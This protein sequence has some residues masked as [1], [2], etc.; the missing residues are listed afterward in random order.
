MVESMRQY[1]RQQTALLLGRL[2]VAVDR[3]ARV[4]DAASIHSIYGWPC[5]A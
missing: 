2:S 4:A 1:A 5:V 3:A